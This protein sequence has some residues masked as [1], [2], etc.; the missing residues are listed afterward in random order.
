MTERTFW[1]SLRQRLLPYGMLVRVESLT[2]AGIPDVCYCI[3]GTT[4]WFEMKFMD[5]WPTSEYIKVP[6][7]T[8]DQLNF[9]I[10]WDLAQGICFLVLKIDKTEFLFNAKQ[11][12]RLHAGG[13]PTEALK[14]MTPGI[15]RYAIYPKTTPRLVLALQSKGMR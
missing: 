9:L 6:G 1:F 15:S 13:V 5:N 11:A 3:L 4:G 2:I 8:K 10:D 12:A 14:E 7:F